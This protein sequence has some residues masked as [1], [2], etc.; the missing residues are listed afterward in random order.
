MTTLPAPLATD[1]GTAHTAAGPCSVCRQPIMRGQRYALVVPDGKAAHTPCIV[2]A[3]LR[4][5]PV[6]VIR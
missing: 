2:L 1:A 4:R 6:P 3:A 5:R